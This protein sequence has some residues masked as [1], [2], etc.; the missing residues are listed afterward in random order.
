M[1][2]LLTI[3]AATRTITTSSDERILIVFFFFDDRAA[4]CV[5]QTNCATSEET[6]RELRN[7]ESEKSDAPARSASPAPSG[8]RSSRRQFMALAEGSRDGALLDA[9]GSAAAGQPRDET[10]TKAPRGSET[11]SSARAKSASSTTPHPPI[12]GARLLR[13]VVKAHLQGLRTRVIRVGEEEAE[14]V[15]P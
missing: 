5:G 4:A 8:T 14:H 1:D 11:N 6:T 7:T 10:S 13:R 12:P 3:A 9:G 2:V 15:E